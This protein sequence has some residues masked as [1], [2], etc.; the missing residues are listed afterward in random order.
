[1]NP[2]GFD[3]RLV[4]DRNEEVLREVRSHRLAKWRR[5]ER[6]GCP[7]VGPFFGWSGRG[8]ISGFSG[9]GVP[10]GGLAQ[11][12]PRGGGEAGV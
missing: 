6:A 3:N 11:V 5:A 4:T 7:G 1:M 10:T 12:V 8:R 9:G 2:T